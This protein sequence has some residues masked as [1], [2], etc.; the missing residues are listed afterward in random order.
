M[1]VT[2]PLSKLG[3]RTAIVGQPGRGYI[4][5]YD[6]KKEKKKIPHTITFRWHAGKFIEGER[7]YNSHAAC[8]IDKPD[9]G[10]LDISNAGHYSVNT[11]NGI[12]TGDIIKNSSS[13]STEKRPADFR[14]VNAIN[15]QG[16]AA[17]LRG[18][19]Y[20]FDDV[21]QWT[22][23]DKGLPE[24]FDINDI[25]G[26]SSTDIYVVGTKGNVWHFDGDV[27]L[28]IVIPTTVNLAAVAC[29]DDGKVYIAGDDG[30]LIV[31]KKSSWNVIDH[32]GTK[33]NLCDVELFQRHVYVSTRSAVYR[34]KDGKLETVDFGDDKPSSWHQLSMTK[35]VMWSSSEFDI[36]SFDGKKWTRVA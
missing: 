33:D 12:V 1:N 31:G 20:R 2:S 18:L 6:P 15:G 28:A 9:V 3:I 23:I 22:R 19:V 13:R 17:G 36:M 34:L 30:V 5:A 11:V 4:F 35:G 24:S 7:A 10:L 14:S 32:G 16:Y 25:H 29:A 26:F 8:L 27:W 21:K